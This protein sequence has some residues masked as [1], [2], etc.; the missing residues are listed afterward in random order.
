LDHA[1]GCDTTTVNETRPRDLV[2]Q[3]VTHNDL[4]PSRDGHR[5]IRASG[6]PLNHT[7]SGS[8][9][10]DR[11]FRARSPLRVTVASRAACEMAARRHQLD[12]ASR[13][14]PASSRWR[15]RWRA[16]FI[17]LPQDAIS[18]HRRVPGRDRS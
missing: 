7:A 12:G 1:D 17:R 5:V 10:R 9:I 18:H 13:P 6:C 11:Q 3:E 2:S 8:Q 16:P 15:A 14:G 4:S